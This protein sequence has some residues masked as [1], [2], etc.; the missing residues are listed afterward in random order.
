VGRGAA[1]AVRGLVRMEALDAVFQAETL[2]L[3]DQGLWCNADRYRI[4]EVRAIDPA[5]EVGA[6]SEIKPCRMSKAKAW[7]GGRNEMRGRCRNNDGAG[8]RRIVPGC[9]G[10][11]ISPWRVLKRK[12]RML[13]L[14]LKP[15]RIT[16]RRTQRKATSHSSLQKFRMIRQSSSPAGGHPVGGMTLF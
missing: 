14:P 1:I 16:R 10:C 4:I 7:V 8:G 12:A 9:V 15:R 3:K 2:V 6:C 5:G 13:T 11:R